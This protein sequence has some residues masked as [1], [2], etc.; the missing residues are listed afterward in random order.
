MWNWHFGTGTIWHLNL[1]GPAIF[2]YTPPKTNMTMENQ[3]FE[4]VSPILKKIGDFPAIAM[5][6]NS[7]GCHFPLYHLRKPSSPTVVACI[8]GWCCGKPTEFV[9]FGDHGGAPWRRNLYHRK[10]VGLKSEPT[11]VKHM[12]FL[13]FVVGIWSFF[14]VEYDF[15]FGDMSMNFWKDGRMIY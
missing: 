12:F 9:G 10:S 3:P 15:F 11:H 13:M 5:L 4:D 2:S 14:D 7:G 6:V 1:P 8:P